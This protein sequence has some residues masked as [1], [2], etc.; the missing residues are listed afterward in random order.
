MDRSA[1]LRELTDE[2]LAL[3]VAAGSRPCYEELVYRYTSRLFHFLRARIGSDQDTEDL[4]QETFLKTYRNIERY[5][6]EWKFSTWIYTVAL[7]LSISFYRSRKK[8]GTPQELQSR[9]P[10]PEDL[11]IQKQESQN[12]WSLARGLKRKQFQSLWLRYAED[13]STQEIA[14]LLRVTPVQ[15]RVM[16]H[17]GRTNL[18]KLYNRPGR[19]GELAKGT[20]AQQKVPLL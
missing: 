12:I 20:A 1:E 18:A 19:A 10:N 3:R 2:E 9:E 6:P 15:V 11:V 14:E 13:M 17:R 5:D 7:R 8:P 16:L 4:V